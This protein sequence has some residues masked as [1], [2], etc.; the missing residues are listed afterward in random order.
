VPI[1]GIAR[2]YGVSSLRRVSYTI[3][4][5]LLVLH[6]AAPSFHPFEIPQQSRDAEPVFSSAKIGAQRGTLPRLLARSQA[7][8]AGLAKQ[9]RS[10]QTAGAKFAALPQAVPPVRPN[11]A[12]GPAIGL[13][14]C[15]RASNHAHDFEARAPPSL[16]A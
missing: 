12:A 3:A 14:A 7:L 11:D 2:G 8:E 10:I 16:T 1:C 5:I 4:A 9:S 13:S 15:Q 6:W